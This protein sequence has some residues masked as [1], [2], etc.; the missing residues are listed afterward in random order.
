MQKD[1]N[2]LKISIMKIETN[3]EHILEALDD[4]KEQHTE[5]MQKMEDWI[6][7]S[8]KKF[9]S[10]WTE[11]VLVWAGMAIG[12]TLIVALLSLIIK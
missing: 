8:E 9:A 11:R 5:I 3:Y 1:I 10:K 2:N 6:K 4:N 7:A 12:G